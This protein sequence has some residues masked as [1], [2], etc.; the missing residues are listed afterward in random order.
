MR[1]LPGTATIFQLRQLG[2]EANL[3]IVRFAGSAPSHE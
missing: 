2:D 3:V 1:S